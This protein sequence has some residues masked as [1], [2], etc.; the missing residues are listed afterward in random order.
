MAWLYLMVQKSD[1]SQ[2]Y[3]SHGYEINLLPHETVIFAKI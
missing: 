2:R 1:N 3:D